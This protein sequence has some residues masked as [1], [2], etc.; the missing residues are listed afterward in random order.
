MREDQCYPINKDVVNVGIVVGIVV[1]CV[2]GVIGI[3]ISIY[4][5]RKNRQEPIHD[6]D[7]SNREVREK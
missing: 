2:T 4:C 5:Y 7:E 1:G 6:E 3:I